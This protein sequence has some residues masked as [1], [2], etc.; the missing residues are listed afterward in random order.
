MRKIY[1]ITIIFLFL[2]F[3]I[4]AGSKYIYGNDT[5]IL[6]NLLELS[7]PCLTM[8][9]S[10]DAIKMGFEAITIAG[11]LGN[12]A[13]LQKAYETLGHAFFQ[14]N[15]F[16]L[17]IHYFLEAGYLAELN[18]DKRELARICT[19]IAPVY[20]YTNNIDLAVS[21]YETS[22]QLYNQNISE[23]AQAIAKLMKTEILRCEEKYE[24]AVDNY[25]EV[26]DILIRTNETYWTD[27]IILSLGRIYISQLRKGQSVNSIDAAIRKLGYR[28]VGS[29]LNRSCERWTE[30]G[31]ITNTITGLELL[32][33]YFQLTNQ[34][35]K[36]VEINKKYITLSDS[37]AQLNDAMQIAMMMAD[38]EIQ[39]TDKKLELLEA[40]SNAN[41]AHM[42]LQKQQQ[43]IIIIIALMLVLLGFGL[44]SRIVTIR[45]TKVQLVEINDQLGLEKMRAE[46]GERFK[47]QFLTNVS[48]EIR[49]PMNAIMGM[50]NLM[51]KN[52]HYST[53]ERFLEVMSISSRHL[54]R[55]I[56]DILDLSKLES[57]MMDLEK[58]S[59]SI[60]TIC[61]EVKQNF[62]SLAEK[63]G[64]KFE[65]IIDDKIPE[66]LNGDSRILIQIFEQLCRNAIEYT[67][68][69]GITILCKRIGTTKNMVIVGIT[70]M[71]SGSGIARSLH[72]K[73]FSEVLGEA[74]FDKQMLDTSGL[75]LVIIK[76]MIELQGG[77]IMFDSEPGK[78]TTFYFEIPYEIGQTQAVEKSD[79]IEKQIITEHVKG[80]RILLVEDNEFN[81]M[82]A[83]EELK[84]AIEDVFIDVA[85]NG[86]IAVNKVL[87][88]YYD[89]VL[90]DI[91]MPVLNG[92]DATRTIRK[93]EGEISNIP[94]IAMT[95]NIMKSEVDKCFDAGMN[96]YIS[97]PFE[98]ENLLKE[99][100]KNIRPKK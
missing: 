54:L 62:W 59:F 75:E 92:Y 36:L 44:R 32:R 2:T 67:E 90:M 87:D 74:Q 72:N 88:N 14:I 39:Q 17:S 71:D 70:V 69:G 24:E 65:I 8:G 53:Q 35:G 91:Q 63:K 26:Y 27:Q 33:G 34:H 56:N 45:K 3:S 78:G 41:E 73:V 52:K 84:D 95:A 61:E 81:I 99:L 48:H 31:N 9:N 55:L 64:I 13:G 38:F 49:T 20:E 46:K 76:Q 28:S 15:E 96:G 40:T 57:G 37:I 18:T 6:N 22:S 79:K 80:V 82:V 1:N 21:N 68:K 66:D 85:T 50:T 77:N 97:K 89:I 23:T 12:T 98:T 100:Y 86:Q 42:Q 25:Y 43:I 10:Q 58:H 51:I 30:Q 93:L 7:K 60:K 16:D 19:S 29:L 5:L 11:N 94:I 4:G 83:T 47:E